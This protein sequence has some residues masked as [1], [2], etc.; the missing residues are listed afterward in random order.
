MPIVLVGRLTWNRALYES[1][2]DAPVCVLN[3]FDAAAHHAHRI[4]HALSGSLFNRTD[5]WP[6]GGLQLRADSVHFDARRDLG[7]SL[8]R[9]GRWRSPHS[10]VAHGDDL[11]RHYDPSWN[12]YAT[13]SS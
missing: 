1:H 10:R 7:P 9:P 6:R 8:G 13:Q 4:R 12:W 11:W 5:A 2:S 3:G